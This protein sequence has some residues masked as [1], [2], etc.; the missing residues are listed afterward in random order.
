MPLINLIKLT[1]ALCLLAGC[2]LGA[3]AATISITFG[4]AAAGDGSGLTSAIAGATV[5]N[6]NG[7][8]P[9]PYSGAGGLATGST[10]TYAAPA[11]DTT[12]YMSVA[13]NSPSGSE[14]A[15]Y[16]HAYNYFGLY[17]G[18]IDT[19][20]SL[21][22]ISGGTTIATLTGGDVIAA[23]AQFGDRFDAGAN[24]Y[25]NFSLSGGTFDSVRLSSTQYAFE[26][27]NHAVASVP[28]PGTFSLLSLGL[29]AIG[30]GRRTTRR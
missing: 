15:S 5:Y 22:F 6:F 16:A 30:L 4:G 28:E 1:L 27:D 14:L 13:L 10:G 23:G 7:A 19:Y 25:V 26:S 18:S 21:S 29:A 9:S 12:Q 20:N 17:W 2:A 11:G 8:L 3:Q 24:R